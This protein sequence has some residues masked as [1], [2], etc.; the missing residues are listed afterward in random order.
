[1]YRVQLA[2]LRSV[3]EKAEAK[4]RAQEAKRKAEEARRRAEE[5]EERLR[6]DALPFLTKICFYSR[7]SIIK[8][9]ALDSTLLLWD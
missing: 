7:D 1:V 9:P 4:R 5:E 2:A 8:T 6:F 3:G